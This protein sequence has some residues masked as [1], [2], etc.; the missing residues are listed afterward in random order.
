MS[1]FATNP[2]EVPTK[3][4][5]SSCKEN[6]GNGGGG[7]EAMD[8]RRRS[9]ASLDVAASIFSSMQELEASGRDLSSLG[10]C[11]LGL[12]SRGLSGGMVGGGGH[13]HLGG[14][15]GSGYG[16]VEGGH[17]GGLGLTGN[18]GGGVDFHRDAL[19][20]AALGLRDSNRSLASFSVYPAPFRPHPRSSSIRSNAS[21]EIDALLAGMNEPVG[22][23][24]GDSVGATISVGGGGGGPTCDPAAA[25][26]A[27]TAALRRIEVEEMLLQQK[28][29]RGIWPY[30]TSNGGTKDSL[31]P[32]L[33]GLASLFKGNLMR[34]YTPVQ[35]SPKQQLSHRHRHN[36]HQQQQQLMMLQQLRDIGREERPRRL[37]SMDFTP[38]ELLLEV[39]R[40]KRSMATTMGK[41][42]SDIGVVGGGG[43]GGGGE[44]ITKKQGSFTAAGIADLEG[45]YDLVNLYNLMGNGHKGT[46]SMNL[47]GG[48]GGIRDGEVEGAVLSSGIDRPLDNGII[49]DDG[50]GNAPRR[51]LPS[52]S[53]RAEGLFTGGERGG[54]LENV[55]ITVPTMKQS[56]DRQRRRHG[57]S[58]ESPRAEGLFTGGERG[59]ELENVVITVPTMKQSLKSTDRQRRRHGL[60]RESPSST[61]STIVT[62]PPMLEGDDAKETDVKGTNSNKREKMMKK[63]HSSTASFDALLS[64][65]AKVEREE[66]DESGAKEDDDKSSSSFASSMG[67][68]DGGSKRD[69]GPSH[70]EAS[71]HLEGNASL[72]GRTT[73]HPSA[74]PA[75]PGMDAH[76][77]LTQSEMAMM[78]EQL[79]M[80]ELALREQRLREQELQDQELQEEHIQMQHRALRVN[81]LRERLAWAAALGGGGSVGVDSDIGHGLTSLLRG[82]DRDVTVSGIGGLR[83]FPHSLPSFVNP[84]LMQ[85]M[86][87]RVQGLPGSLHLNQADDHTPD[88]KKVAPT[89]TAAA[90]PRPPSPKKI[91]P[92]E[93]LQLFLDT[94]GDDAKK[95]CE[96]MLHAISETEKSLVAIHAWDRSQGLRKCHSR[97]VVKTR[98]SRAQVKAFLTGNDLPV[99]LKKR[100]KRKK[101]E[102]KEEGEEDDEVILQND[103]DDEEEDMHPQW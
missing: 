49:S 87:A 75:A 102:E 22:G 39:T 56:T 57:L 59:G 15:M 19:V 72:R 6:G 77:S 89:P 8:R 24:G 76:A 20:G 45:N 81:A 93:S 41:D 18:G 38:E 34:E 55:V 42:M 98:R 97:T 51:R 30:Q 7:D 67:M 9:S 26:L 35:N 78:R 28:Q 47:L 73:A 1:F 37:H 99:E 94:Y 31:L 29:H 90:A 14:I 53:R 83:S 3:L 84:N 64:A 33:D 74:A 91:S 4:D 25:L 103:E 65:L 60:S 96:S 62:D 63:S 10:L 85:A 86:L 43:G 101:T 46:S 13:P 70:G 79:I 88:A 100:R 95:S 40:R 44:G 92:Q 21:V 11:S 12:G 68:T 50:G 52:T 69:V 36:H 16:M 17:M 71:R 32:G 58:R 54:E 23:G 82:F 2:I 5:S 48:G 66:N 27:Q 80:H 61:S